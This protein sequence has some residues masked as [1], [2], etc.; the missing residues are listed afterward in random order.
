MFGKKTTLILGAGAS[1]P[2]DY[3]LSR[4]LIEEI[5]SMGGPEYV[6]LNI[7]PTE[8]QAFQSDLRNSH[9]PSID[10]FLEQRQEFLRAGKL[11]IAYRITRYENPNLILQLNWY[12]RLVNKLGRTFTD[13]PQNQ[14][15][16]VTFNYDRSLEHFLFESIKAR[17]GKTDDEVADALT[18]IPIHHVYGRLGRLPWQKQLDSEI[19]PARKYGEQDV[20][21]I[22]RSADGIRLIHERNEEE[23]LQSVLDE[24]LKDS[25]WIFILGFGYQ[26]ENMPWI[27]CASERQ[28]VR[29]TRFGLTD[30]QTQVISSRYKIGFQH[31]SNSKVDTFLADE[32][33]FLNEV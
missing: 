12:S 11:A 27:R 6:A 21:A 4:R 24:T 16:I 9:Q 2:Y 23:R 33:A 22:V 19:C 20:N 26:E 30:A 7:N 28:V 29:A 3:P 18:S 1:E 5:L 14:L 32:V 8:F 15:S 10:A 25:E 13:I 17:F 31:Y